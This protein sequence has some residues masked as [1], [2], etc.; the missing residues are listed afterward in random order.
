MAL[1]QGNYQIQ[2]QRLSPLQRLGSELLEIPLSELDARI[3]LEQEQNPYLEQRLEALEE[4]QKLETTEQEGRRIHKGEFLD[5]WFQDDGEQIYRVSK[6]DDN[7]EKEFNRSFSVSLAEDLLQQLQ[8]SRIK[9]RDY[10]I[11]ELI[12][13]NLDSNGYLQRSVEAICDDYFFEHNVDLKKEEVEK[14]LALIRSFEPAGIAAVD[15]QDCLMLQINRMSSENPDTMLAKRV[16]KDYWNSFIHKQYDFII[17]RLEV[18]SE[19]F[20]RVLKII[21]SLNPY[22]GCGEENEIENSYIL[23]DFIVWYADKEVKFSLN[24]QYKRNLSVNADG[25]RMLADLEKKKHRDEKTIQFLK[26]KI[27]KAGL[28]IE[29]FKKR[30][31]TLNTIMQAI[32]SLQYDYFVAGEKSKFK[33]LKYEDIKKITGFT[34]STISRMVNKKYAQTHFGTF[35]LKDFFSYTLINAQ[36]QE[37]SSTAVRE[38]LFEIVEKE[39]K[40]S[41]M[42]DEEL[43]ALL[44][45]QGFTISRRTVAKYRDRLGIPPASKRKQ[46]L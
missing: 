15:L 28:F 5:Y 35:K 38:H 20:E 31:E 8:L 16:I 6:Q 36:G 32:I 14:V 1:K 19:T 23:P 44:C 34:E 30:E 11:G 33:P 39:D 29:A 40:K 17:K 9:E 2:K 45:E 22:P 7:T 43:A 42:T 27:E 46:R 18:D 37:V 21:Q 24:K 4:P 25:I 10:Q 12:I 41:P 3:E 26:E 13:G